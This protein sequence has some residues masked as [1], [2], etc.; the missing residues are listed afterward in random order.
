MPVY[1]NI[2]KP[3][4]ADYTEVNAQGKEQY[5]QSDI[6]YDD[7]SIYYDGVNQAAYT[8][9]SKPSGGGEVLSGYATGLLIPPTY[10]VGFG[11]SSYT[12]INKP[13]T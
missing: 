9:I 5:D 7:S 8:D 3:T 12:N 10:A 13:T 1:T 11:V 6:T 2:A 4:G